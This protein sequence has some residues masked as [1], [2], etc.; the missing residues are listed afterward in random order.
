M[1]TLTAG[2]QSSDKVGKEQ[3]TLPR[4]VLGG[5]PEV[6]SLELD[7]TGFSQGPAHPAGRSLWVWAA[8][9]LAPLQLL[10]PR[11]EIGC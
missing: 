5:F 11:Q 3:L 10:T 4:A 9:G 2:V 7:L 1:L 6:A 8:W